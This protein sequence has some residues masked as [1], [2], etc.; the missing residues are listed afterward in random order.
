MSKMVISAKRPIQYHQLCVGGHFSLSL[1]LSLSFSF[2]AGMSHFS[3]LVRTV[4][5]ANK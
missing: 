5:I 2:R 4:I 3:E 1:S